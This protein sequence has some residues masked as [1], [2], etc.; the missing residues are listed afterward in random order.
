MLLSFSKCL[1]TPFPKDL[2]G[3]WRRWRAQAGDRLRQAEMMQGTKQQRDK[4][5]PHAGA[6]ETTLFCWET[7]VQRYLPARQQLHLQEAAP[8]TWMCQQAVSFLG[9]RACKPPQRHSCISLKDFSWNK[10]SKPLHLRLPDSTGR[11]NPER[12]GST[13]HHWQV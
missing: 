3:R 8:S 6:E 5:A 2:G 7:A 1:V 4:G 10:K 11:Q 9:P 13:G 12:P